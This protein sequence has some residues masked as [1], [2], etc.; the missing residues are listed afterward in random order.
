M[1]T[2]HCNSLNAYLTKPTIKK[3]QEYRGSST[4]RLMLLNESFLLDGESAK[5]VNK[6]H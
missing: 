5:D 2:A 6:I 1:L 4:Y 3:D